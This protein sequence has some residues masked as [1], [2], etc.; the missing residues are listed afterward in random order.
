MLRNCIFFE[1]AKLG[2]KISEPPVVGRSRGPSL[3]HETPPYARCRLA[4]VRKDSL[5]PCSFS[6]GQLHVHINWDGWTVHALFI[7][8]GRCWF[9]QRNPFR[10]SATSV[11]FVCIFLRDKSTSIPWDLSSRMVWEERGSEEYA[12]R[13]GSGT[14]TSCRRRTWTL[15]PLLISHEVIRLWS[16]LSVSKPCILQLAIEG[17]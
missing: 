1:H 4:K 11:A 5:I 2:L 3:L 8:T 7:K 9:Y 16:W 12:D 10:E 15:S 17:C 14:W 6:V 13:E